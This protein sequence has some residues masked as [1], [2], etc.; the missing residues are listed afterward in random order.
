V[1]FYVRMVV[2]ACVFFM[3]GWVVT[4]CVFYVRMGGHGMGFFC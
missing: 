4:A 2:T 1:F 3:L